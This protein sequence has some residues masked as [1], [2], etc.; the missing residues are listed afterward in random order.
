LIP[1][2]SAQTGRGRLHVDTETLCT[3]RPGVFA[4]GDLVTGPNTVVDAIA[5]GKKAAEVIDRYLRGKELRM[6]SKITLPKFFIEPP[7]IGDEELEEA[8]RE[9]P[10]TL[11][12]G[13]RRKNFAEVEMSLSV[14]QAKHEAR[15]CLRCDLEFTQ[16][17]ND[18][19]SEPAAIGEK[20]I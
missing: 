16:P 6:P 4:G 12:V 13:S 15:R 20:S 10:A 8:E 7:E 18:N 17:K 1:K 3:N 5:A 2:P 19:E 9:E 11:P 14:D